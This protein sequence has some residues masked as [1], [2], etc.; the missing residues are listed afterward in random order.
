MHKQTRHQDIHAYVRTISFV[1]NQV[2]FILM[3]DNCTFL[4]RAFANLS[5]LTHPLVYDTSIDTDNLYCVLGCENCS[6]SNSHIQ[7]VGTFNEC[8]CQFIIYKPNF[9]Q[10]L[11]LNWLQHFVMYSFSRL[12][13]FLSPLL[14]CRNFFLFLSLIFLSLFL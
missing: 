7:A 5:L 12:Y 6:T 9:I 2:L 10:S 8:M 3:M 11:T 1:P 14:L 4:H 13:F